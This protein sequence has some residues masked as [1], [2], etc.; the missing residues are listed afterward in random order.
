MIDRKQGLAM[1]NVTRTTRR[2]RATDRRGEKESRWRPAMVT[3]IPELTRWSGSG[4]SSGG[5][6]W[7]EVGGG[8]GGCC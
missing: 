6:E 8:G 5:V 4:N 3:Y 7:S 1:Q 2:I